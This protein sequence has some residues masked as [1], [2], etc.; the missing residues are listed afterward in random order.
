[1]RRRR[2]ERAHDYSATRRDSRRE[3]YAQPV[4][5][6]GMACWTV[7]SM[8]CWSRVFAVVRCL[9][10]PLPPD[11]TLVVI[12]SVEY[13]RAFT[14]VRVLVHT[15]EEGF[16]GV[17]GRERYSGSLKRIPARDDRSPT[18]GVAG[19][20]RSTIEV[21]TN[22]SEAPHL[23]SSIPLPKTDFSKTQHAS[24]RIIP[25]PESTKRVFFEV[26]IGVKEPRFS[27]T[28]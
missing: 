4:A 7:P 24:R 3:G 28:K 14:A 22:F 25:W 1:M 6:M 15:A 9:Q 2:G 10:K 11:K 16:R 8:L 13:L 19:R 27:E 26:K 20:R 12:H 5:Q 23:R 17:A 21:H 18:G